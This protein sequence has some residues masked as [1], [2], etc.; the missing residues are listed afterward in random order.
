MGK[1]YLIVIPARGNSKGIAKKNIKLLNGYPLI[2][3]T[4]DVAL[5]AVNAGI[6]SNAILSTDSVE[7]ANI[8]EIY[9]LK[10][11]FMRPKE[12][13]EDTVKS[14]DVLKHVLERLRKIGEEYDAVVTLQPTSPQRSYSDL[15]SSIEYF[16]N[17]SNDSLI[18]VYEDEKANGYN[19]Y[20]KIEG[21]TLPLRKEHNIGIRRQDMEEI[22]IRNGA[23]YISD[24]DLIRRRNLMIGDFPELFIMPKNRSTDIDRIEDFEYVEWLMRKK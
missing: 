16:N 22:Y 8:S 6:V 11:P 5:Q 24:I 13:G 20:R 23:I 1:R 12:L 10:V 14:I 15:E 7:I 3:Y 19:Y 17:S 21:K 18:S 9:G 2:K 4:I